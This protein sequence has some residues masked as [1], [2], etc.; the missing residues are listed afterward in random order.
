MPSSA[1]FFFSLFSPVTAALLTR[2]YTHIWSPGQN[3]ACLTPTHSLSTQLASRPT[4]NARSAHH[5]HEMTDQVGL[6]SLNVSLGPAQYILLACGRSKD[7]C[8][9]RRAAHRQ[10]SQV[11]MSYVY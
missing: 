11:V 1:V 10:A 9:H 8:T 4:R 7:A 5:F 3:V 2:T 6:I